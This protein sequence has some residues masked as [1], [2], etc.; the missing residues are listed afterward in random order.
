M[1]RTPTYPVEVY[2]IDNVRPDPHR[3]RQCGCRDCPP[4]PRALRGVLSTDYRTQITFQQ[5]LMPQLDL[6]FDMRFP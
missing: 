6:E 5:L 1:T 2:D 3:R 4:R